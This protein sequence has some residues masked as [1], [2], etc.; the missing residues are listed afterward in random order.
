[1]DKRKIRVYDS[2]ATTT[3][4]RHYVSSSPSFALVRMQDGKTYLR[5]PM[6]LRRLSA[7]DVRILEILKVGAAMRR[8]HLIVGVSTVAITA[9]VFGAVLLRLLR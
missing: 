7:D 4:D 1:M 3:L 5:G 2:G 9:L 8:T 6:G